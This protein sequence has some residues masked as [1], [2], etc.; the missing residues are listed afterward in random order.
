M[1][2]SGGGPTLHAAQMFPGSTASGDMNSLV[3]CESTA[4]C[5]TRGGSSEDAVT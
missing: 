2:G 1:L 4:M 5:I 3:S